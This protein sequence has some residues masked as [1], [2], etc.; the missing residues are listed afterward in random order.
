MCLQRLKDCIVAVRTVR[1][2]EQNGNGYVY[3]SVKRSTKVMHFYL[4]FLLKDIFVR[5]VV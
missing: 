4:N 2:V 1:A 5:N 3:S